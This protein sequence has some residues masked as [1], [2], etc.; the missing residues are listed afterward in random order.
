VIA[1]ESVVAQTVDPLAG[2]YYVEALT[3]EIEAR[4]GEYLYTVLSLDK[5]GKGM[6]MLQAI[7]QGYVQRE[8][9]GAAYEYQRAVETGEAVV[10]GVNR[11]VS[12]GAG[13]EVPIQRIDPELE[14]RQVERVR[15]LRARRDAGRWTAALQSVTDAAMSRENLMP[16]ILEAVESEATVGEIADRLRGVFGEYRETVVV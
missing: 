15:A 16:R 8:I 9:Q 3:D 6:G 7:E 11:F 12:D 5:S 2:S 1:Y 14:Q 4:A 13:A 10:V